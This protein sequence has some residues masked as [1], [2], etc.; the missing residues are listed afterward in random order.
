MKIGQFVIESNSETEWDKYFV[1]RI[2]RLK[3]ITGIKVICLFCHINLTTHVVHRNL[4]LELFHSSSTWLGLIILHPL[5]PPPSWI[6]LRYWNK[7][8]ARLATDQSQFTAGI[9]TY[10][11]YC[12]DITNSYSYAA[13]YMYKIVV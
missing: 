11:F 5:R 10:I 9:T 4:L 8:N 3:M 6:W 13:R 2:M 1:R 7:Y 12:E